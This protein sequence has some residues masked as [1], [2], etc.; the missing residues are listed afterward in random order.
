MFI[1]KN[2]ARNES[3]V[4]IVP[5][6]ATKGNAIGTIEAEVD[7]SSLYNLIPS[8]ISSAKKNN[9]KEPATANELASIP[10]NFKISSPTKRKAIII[11]ADTNDAFPD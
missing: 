6:P 4:V 2:S 8:I 1:E 7:L 11:A 5:A 9:T 10:T 3:N